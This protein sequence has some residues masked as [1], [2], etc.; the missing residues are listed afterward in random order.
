MPRLEH[1][2]DLS[3]TTDEALGG[4]PSAWDDDLSEKDWAA[5]NLDYIHPL[6]AERRRRLQAARERL[7]LRAVADDTLADLLFVLGLEDL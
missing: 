3:V 4:K 6:V 7:R 1:V 5:R 2:V